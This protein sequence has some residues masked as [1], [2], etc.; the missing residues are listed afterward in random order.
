M[1]NVQTRQVGGRVWVRTV[2]SILPNAN[3]TGAIWEEAEEP[4]AFQRCAHAALDGAG[5]RHRHPHRRLALLQPPAGSEGAGR[6]GRGSAWSRSTSSAR[7]GTSDPTRSGS[8]SPATT[9]R[10]SRNGLSPSTPWSIAPRPTRALRGCA[11]SCAGASAT[12]RPASR[13]VNPR[14]SASMRCPP[15]AR[16]RCSDGRDRRSPARRICA[17]PAVGSR[18][19][20]S[21]P[22]G[23]PRRSGKHVCARRRRP[24]RSL[25]SP[26]RDL[27]RCD[28]ERRRGSGRSGHGAIGRPWARVPTL[29]GIRPR[30][31][32]GRCRV[33]GRRDRAT[34]RGGL[35]PHR[36]PGAPRIR[37]VPRRP[38]PAH[39]GIGPR[40]R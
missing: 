22:T 15:T 19:P 18:A 37:Q 29:T 23:F 16:T 27:E 12:W 17:R 2:D 31:K 4:K 13:S 8:A 34:E 10:R 33:P 3:Q 24:L 6:S 5:G 38:P 35:H 7:P 11:G 28:S 32:T 14:R 39:M 1:M 30:R 36:H 21:V 26:D 20:C 25:R 40:P 9:R